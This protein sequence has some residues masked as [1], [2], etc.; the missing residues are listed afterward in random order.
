MTGVA[1]VGVTHED[2]RTA[3]AVV[4]D[5]CRNLLELLVLAVEVLLGVICVHMS[6]VYVHLNA[7]RKSNEVVAEALCHRSVRTRE[8]AAVLMV[9]CVDVLTAERACSL[10][11][12]EVKT[13]TEG[14]RLASEGICAEVL[15]ISAEALAEVEEVPLVVCD[16][17][18]DGTV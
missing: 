5:P 15:R 8:D 3:V 13:I 18:S 1:A 2:H 11:C 14:L 4:C 7:V 6:D 10:T 9:I 12:A 16:H 17:G